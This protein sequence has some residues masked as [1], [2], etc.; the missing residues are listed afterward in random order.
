MDMEQGTKRSAGTERFGLLRNISTFQIR[1][2]R[3]TGYV[4]A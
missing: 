3:E 4:M 2:N 1:Q